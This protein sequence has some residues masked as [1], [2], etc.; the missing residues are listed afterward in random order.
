MI[1][2]NIAANITKPRANQIQTW[3]VE[4]AP[5]NRQENL[6]YVFVCVCVCVCVYVCV[7]VCVCVCT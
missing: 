2:R 4:G 7:C 5:H 6:N 1:V 3:T